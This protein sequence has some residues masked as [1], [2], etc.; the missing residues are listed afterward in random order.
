MLWFFRLPVVLYRPG[1]PGYERP[2]GLRC[3]MIT[4]KGRRTGKSHIVMLDLV[5]HDPAWDRYYVQPGWGRN[6][7]WVKNVEAHSVI[8]VQIGRQRFQ[9]KVTDVS[10]SEGGDWIF[11]FMKARPLQTRLIGEKILGV[12]LKGRSDEE[13]RAL[14]NGLMVFALVPLEPKA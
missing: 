11:R 5:G 13:V 1:M 9:A 12:R 4:T 2:L 8:E 14:T 7:D 10:G 3:I 6:C